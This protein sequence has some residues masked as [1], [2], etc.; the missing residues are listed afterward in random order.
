[1]NPT[2][3][4]SPPPPGPLAAASTPGPAA[5]RRSSTGTAGHWHG[6]VQ[7]LLAV[8]AFFMANMLSC[9]RFAIH[10]VT[11]GHVSTLS[12]TT[13][14]VTD[15]LDGPTRIVV[16]FVKDSALKEKTWRLAQ[17]YADARPGLI[18]AR[19]LD[20]V[21]DPEGARELAKRHHVEFKNNTVLVIKGKRVEI[22]P[23]TTMEIVR[24][25][26]DG[27]PRAVGFAGENAITTALLRL[28]EPTPPVVY[29]ISGKGSWP[30]TTNGN[31]SDTLRAL[32]PNHNAVLKELSLDGLEAIPDDAAALLLVN[33]RYDLS[34]KEV[35]L[36]RE[37]WEQRKGGLC[38]ML[39]P[40]NATPNLDAFL[41][42]HGVTPDRRTLM[43]SVTG[44]VGASRELAV[45]VHFLPGAALTD[46]FVNADAKFP[47][48]SI[49]LQVDSNRDELRA[50]GIRPF[51]LAESLP[52]YWGENSPGGATTEFNRGEDAAGPLPV[53]AAIE[54]AAVDDDRVKLPAARMVVFAN[55]HLLDP[56]ALVQVN[57]DFFFSSLNWLLDRHTM[58][59][60]NPRQPVY[61]QAAMT[62]RQS[63]ALHVLLLAGLPAL[64]LFL[65]WLVHQR[66]RS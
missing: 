44:P 54:R 56:D 19:L 59:G 31:G 33:P 10:D 37:F 27:V 8:V 58:I 64:A 53:V 18:R 20:P 13:R 38:V 45:S 60:E 1:M 25:G 30:A 28:L 7:L 22:I 40:E 62:D 24:K 65:A 23:D 41:K 21:R 2:E 39:N 36:L 50:R 43:K 42:F 11:R 4:S 14:Q 3:S 51:I 9:Q 34:G 57:V 52:E 46:P 5:A 49:S 12:A 66:R 61:F 29:L 32:L 26:P 15:A 6:L 48:T 55:P 47:G 63:R 17:A 35:R 16:A